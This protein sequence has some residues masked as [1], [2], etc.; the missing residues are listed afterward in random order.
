MNKARLAIIMC[1]AVFGGWKTAY[2]GEK[3]A[4]P[5][6]KNTVAG[7]AVHL[8]IMSGQSN[9]EGIKPEAAFLPELKKAFPNDE[10]LIAK[11]AVDG[12]SIRLWYKNW[13]PANE[14][15][16]VEHPG[17]A[18]GMIY[19]QLLAKVNK[20]L[21]SKK[22]TTVTLVWLQGESDGKAAAS[23]TPYAESLQG[24]LAQF[25]KD[26]GRDDINFVIGRINTFGSTRAGEWPNWEKVRQA[27]VK[28]AESSPRGAWVDLDD[29]GNLLHY[30]KESYAVIA[31]RFAE[32]AVALIK[33]TSSMPNHDSR[34]YENNSLK[35]ERQPVVYISYDEAAAKKQDREQK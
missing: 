12:R 3:A 9:M 22:P 27:Q 32:K 21:G 1:L 34:S 31:T 16:A 11:M 8:F 25:R 2:A 29:I 17:E 23:G 15:Q 14:K 7:K 18:T 30:P 20:T 24:V 35:G 10:I 26:L 5:P 4:P 13:K 28:V 6:E 19:D 33:K